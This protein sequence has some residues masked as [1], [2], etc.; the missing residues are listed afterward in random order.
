MPVVQNIA[1]PPAPFMP[2][3][4]IPLKNQVV[5]ELLAAGGSV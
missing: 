5:P 2:E 3:F 1:W 4:N